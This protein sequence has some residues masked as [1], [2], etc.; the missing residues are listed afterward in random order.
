MG[1][2]NLKKASSLVVLPSRQERGKEVGRLEVRGQTR[3]NLSLMWGVGG[4]GAVLGGCIVPVYLSQILT[5]SFSSPR[6][7]GPC[8]L[9]VG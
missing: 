8:V 7:S 9:P 4:Q 2:K 6:C 1:R 5:S 3:T